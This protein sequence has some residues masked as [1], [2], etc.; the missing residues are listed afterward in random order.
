MIESCHEILA[1]GG[2]PEHIINS[3]N[4]GAH[5]IYAG[6]RFMSGRSSYT[7][8][9]FDNI[10]T[11]RQLTRDA[12]VKLYIAMNRSI[13]IGEEERWKKFIEQIVL[14]EPDA[15]IIGSFCVY[16]MV[17]EMG[18]KI[19]LH[20]ST[21][22]GIYNP[23]G[24]QMVKSMGFTRLILNTSLNLNEIRYI[25]ESVPELEYEIIAYGGIC[26]NDNHRC[27]LPHGLRRI[28][29]RRETGQEESAEKDRFL[30]SKESTYCQLRLKVTDKSGNEVKS[31]RLMCNPIIDLSPNLLPFMRAGVTSFKIA[32]RERDA[33]FAARAV[34]SLKTGI[35][36]ALGYADS[37]LEH[38]AYLDNIPYA[39]SL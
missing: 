31:G 38:Y 21:F 19:P 26:R 9:G 16:D 39:S 18:I 24:A 3:I 12:G 29:N 20:A 36:T 15:L 17:R 13:P 23:A 22:M 35:K 1:P 30:D 2:S 7:E 25:T 32:G 4:E 33:G 27:N 10:K 5:S 34:K 14:C 37:P 8:M 11:A 6:P 28:G